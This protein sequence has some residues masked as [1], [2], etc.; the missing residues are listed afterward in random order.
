VLGFQFGD[1]WYDL[2]R[3]QSKELT[4]YAS[5]NPHFRIEAM[6]IKSKFGSLL[7]RLVERTTDT[8]VIIG[9]ACQV[10]DRT[11]E[12]TGESGVLCVRRPATHCG[13]LYMVLCDEEAAE[14][15]YD[16]PVAVVAHRAGFEVDQPF[17]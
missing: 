11:C 10:A 14:L 16:D 6:Q 15:G 12:L 13:T 8:D 2:L 4:V 7:F 17:E 1:R 3:A 5:V 9:C